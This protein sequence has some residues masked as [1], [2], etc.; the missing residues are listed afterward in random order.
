[1]TVP[2][3]ISHWA[4]PIISIS[5]IIIGII[6]VV[7]TPLRVFLRIIISVFRPLFR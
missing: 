7:I 2:M 3:M 5:V 6:I 1:M 4:I